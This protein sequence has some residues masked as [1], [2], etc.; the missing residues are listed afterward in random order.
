RM[1]LARAETSVFA[2]REEMQVEL[3]KY[4]QAMIDSQIKMPGYVSIGLSGGSMPKVLAP[5]LGQLKIDPE[6]LRLFLV[7]ERIVEITDQD[8]NYGAWIAALPKELTKCLAPVDLIEVPYRPDKSTFPHDVGRCAVAYESKIKNHHVGPEV[9]GRFPRFDMI[10]LG[11]GPDGHTASL[12]PQA[13]SFRLKHESSAWFVGVEDSPKPPPQRVTLTLASINT[14]A[15]VAFICT[16]EDKA[17]VLKSVLD[18][19]PQYP[20]SHVHPAHGTLRFF[21]DTAAAAKL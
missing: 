10:F 18:R 1:P 21:L 17:T 4:I 9:H 15:H 19:D 12:F 2:S 13:K 5:V 6:R 14:A 11:M 7:D 8:S 20:A 16:G 3:V